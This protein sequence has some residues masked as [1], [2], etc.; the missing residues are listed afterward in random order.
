MRVNKSWVKAE[1][2]FLPLQL[3]WNVHSHDEDIPTVITGM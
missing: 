3:S 2:P 1:V